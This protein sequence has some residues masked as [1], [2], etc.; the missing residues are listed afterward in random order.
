MHEAVIID[1]VRIPRAISKPQGSYAALSA[2]DLLHPLFKALEER[3]ALDTQQV[4]DVL[5]GC[6]TQTADQGANIAKTA[7]LYAGWSNSISGCTLNRFCCSGLDAVNLGAAKIA[8]GIEQLVVAGGVEHMSRVPMFSDQGAW[9]SNPAVAAQTRFVHMGVAADLIASRNHFSRAELDQITLQSHQRAREATDQQ[10]FQRSLVP[11]PVGFGNNTTAIPL[12]EQDEAIRSLT[13]ER[14]AKLPTAFDQQCDES[15]KTVSSVYPNVKLTS[16][17]SI[18]NAPAIVDGASLL[19]LA[20]PDMAQQQ[21]WQPRA[22][23]V[24]FANASCEP[25]QML[26]GHVLATEKILRAN[27]LDAEQIDLWEVNESFAAS[28]LYYQRHFSI[29]EQQINVNGGA[30][31]MGHPLGATGGNLIATLLDELERRHL[32]RGMVAI[33]GGAGVGVA[34]LIERIIP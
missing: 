21:Q 23:I 10:R 15:R 2:V 26:T 28:I 31:A 5:L 1:A 30:I 32:H 33:C 20:S 25:V 12:V 4:D 18:A 11:V 29:R 17:H 19:L 14:L 34:T 8:A 13:P 6:V 9:F 22:R 3:N 27:Q 16:H 24:T 7:S